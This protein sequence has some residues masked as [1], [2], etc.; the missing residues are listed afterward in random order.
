MLTRKHLPPNVSVKSIVERSVKLWTKLVVADN[1]NN[2]SSS[3]SNRS[4][5]Y[6]SIE[7]RWWLR[8]RNIGMLSRRN[9]Q[10]WW[11]WWGL[12]LKSMFLSIIKTM[13]VCGIWVRCRLYF[14]HL[15]KL[16]G[17][18]Q[19]GSCWCTAPFGTP[20]ITID[21]N[22]CHSLRRKAKKQKNAT[23]CKR[24]NKNIEK[25]RKYRH[26][27]YM[28]IYKRRLLNAIKAN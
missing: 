15:Q 27:I 9:A 19:L 17:S 21:F 1:T 28:Y 3:K 16:F 8:Q 10:Y 13:S 22:I 6:N 4:Y 2:N 5:N 11:I 7:A 23:K 26:C 24:K 25:N 20:N 14:C 18:V 12:N